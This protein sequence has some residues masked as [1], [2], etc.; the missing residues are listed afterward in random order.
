MSHTDIYTEC[1][2]LAARKN[3]RGYKELIHRYEKQARML[4]NEGKVRLLVELRA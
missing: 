2:D 1:P 4:V 3:E